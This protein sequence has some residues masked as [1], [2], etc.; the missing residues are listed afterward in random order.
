MNAKKNLICLG[1]N[2]PL[3]Y[4]YSAISVYLKSMTS[5]SVIGVVNISRRVSPE[6][7]SAKSYIGQSSLVTAVREAAGICPY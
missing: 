3:S 6:R 5:I 1:V 7:F 2:N 4:L